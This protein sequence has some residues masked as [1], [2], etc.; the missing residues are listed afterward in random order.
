MLTE[1]KY[2]EG[3]PIRLAVFIYNIY[4]IFVDELAC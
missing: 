2:I 4:R 3:L 1:I